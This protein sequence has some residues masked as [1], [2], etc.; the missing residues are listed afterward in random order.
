[1]YN[2]EKFC[3]Y[4]YTSLYIPI[5]LYN[6]K[7]MIACFPTQEM[8]TYPPSSYLSTLLSTDNKVTYTMT[9]FYSY[10][11]CI[12][13]ENS[14]YC[15]VIGPVNDFPYSD[16]SLEL[17]FKEFFVKKSKL[18]IFSEFFH[19]I[20]TQNLDILINTLLFINYVVNNTELTKKDSVHYISGQFDT[21]INK[22][23]S[24]KCFSEKEE[25]ILNN[26]Y[27]TEHEWMKYIETGNINGIKNFAEYS[28]NSKISIF[29]NNNLRQWKN[30]FIISVTL[31]TRTSIKSGLIPSIAYQLSDIYI[32]QVE[33]L[34]DIDAI[35]S[36]LIQAQI[37][38][39]SR[40]ANSIAPS[41]TDNI[42]RRAIQY[43]RE[44][45]N[46]NLTVSDVAN[47]IGFTRTSL[48]R[49]SKK[50]LGIELS[51]YI[52]KCKME[53]ARDLLEFSNKS[54]GEISNYLCFSSQ[55]HFQRS[56]KNHF[57]ITPQVFRK[58]IY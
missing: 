34:T 10:Y 5:Y 55:S 51:T 33:Q 1:M 57:G 17:M 4:L 50:E 54:I 40:V 27:K 53:E 49:K 13:I 16:E 35:K 43:I 11:G 29:A 31:I 18:E 52:R 30:T 37:D 8:N 21:A 20:P 39:T 24:E 19:K 44:N 46:K 12:K 38:Y 23:C 7:E 45:T 22:K 42:L 14:S 47:Y 32:Q 48:S 41:T 9:R 15:I 36:L 6:N 26:S 56:F 28:L 2:I 58:S 25:G 3:Q